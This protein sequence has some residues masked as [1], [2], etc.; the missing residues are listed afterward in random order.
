MLHNRIPGNVSGGYNVVHSS[1]KILTLLTLAFN[2][3]EQR[4]E[5]HLYIGGYKS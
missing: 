4:N 3:N 1:R 2:D 5:K